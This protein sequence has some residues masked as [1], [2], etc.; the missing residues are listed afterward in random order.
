MVVKDWILEGDA[1]IS[2]QAPPPFLLYHLGELLILSYLQF[3]YLKIGIIRP[4][5]LLTK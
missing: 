5:L 4:N 1:L 2:I 3:P